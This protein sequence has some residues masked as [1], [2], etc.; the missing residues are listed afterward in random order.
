MGDGADKED[1]KEDEE[2]I[3]RKVAAI[4]EETEEERP[5][6]WRGKSRNKELREL[7][8]GVAMWKDLVNTAKARRKNPMR[9]W[10]RG[11]MVVGKLDMMGLKGGE[12]VLSP[13]CINVQ[14]GTFAMAVHPDAGKVVFVAHGYAVKEIEVPECDNKW[15]EETVVDLGTVQ[16][17][18]LSGSDKR[19]VAFKTPTS[20]GSNKVQVEMAASVANMG[21]W[22]LIA[23]NSR[24]KTNPVKMEMQ[25]ELWKGTFGGG[26]RNTVGGCAN[27]VYEVRIK[28]ARGRTFKR[29]ADL[30][31]VRA[32]ELGNVN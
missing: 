4:F 20:G 28:N 27:C 32:L 18:K 23:L 22:N 13:A 6:R 21:K 12:K 2:E 19:S 14:N 16:M 10:K 29:E 31:T 24:G 5:Y 30:T 11:C 25:G 9:D 8:G 3:A 15:Q 17:R 7:N 1:E 26:I